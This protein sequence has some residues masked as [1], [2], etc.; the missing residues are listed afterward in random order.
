ISADERA[1]V[2][3]R[4]ENIEKV[5]GTLNEAAVTAASQGI[6]YNVRFGDTL[7]SIAIKHP[8]LNDVTLWRLLAEK[9]GLGTEVDQSGVPV[10]VIARGDK[11][12]LPTR[13]EIADYRKKNGVL[14]QSSSTWMVGTPSREGGPISSRTSKKCDDCQRLVPSGV[15]MCPGCGNIFGTTSAA[16]GL[17]TI[18]SLMGG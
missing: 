10:A 12:V 3:K 2:E 7:R 6:Q 13:D 18:L 9:N 11:L 17:K 1:D 5:L 8:M 14:T 15:S 16:K 4:K